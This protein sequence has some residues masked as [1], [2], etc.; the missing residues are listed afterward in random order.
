MVR[1][2][3]LLLLRPALRRGAAVLLQG[4]R[5]GRRVRARV[6]RVRARLRRAGRVRP[7]HGR[8]PHRRAA[9]PGVPPARA[10]HRHG[11]PAREQPEFGGAVLREEPRDLPRGPARAQRAGRAGVP[12]QGLRES[13]RA[14][15][16]RHRF[17]SAPADGRV[18]SVGGERRAR[19]PQDERLRL[20]H[21]VV[22]ARAVARA[23]VRGDAHCARVHAPAQGKLPD[24]HVRGDRVL[25]QSALAAT[26]RYLRAGDAHARAHR[27]VRG[28]HAAVQLRLV[29]AAPGCAVRGP[30]RGKGRARGG[31]G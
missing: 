12:Q 1:R 8:L 11:V 27:P 24:Q 29:R 19:L 7:G 22:R 2:G 17:G 25:S 4:D 3:V 16:G 6:D 31:G 14:P 5:A 9:V 15:P 20:R 30:A 23:A 13:R 26:G 18:G 28:D 10:V 21:R